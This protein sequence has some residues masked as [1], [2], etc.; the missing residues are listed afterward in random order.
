MSSVFI[1]PATLDDLTDLY[2]VAIK[3]GDSGSDATGMFRN[4]DMIGEVYVGP[5]VT[6]A[7]E[8]CFALVSKSRAVGYGLCVLD[9]LAFQSRAG[10]SWWPQLQEKY[11]SLAPYIES[12]WLIKE[13]FHPTPSPKEILDE[14]PSHGHIDLLPEFQGQGW[15]RKVMESMETALASLGSPGFHLRVSKHNIRGLKFYAALGYQEIMSRESEVIVGKRLHR[16]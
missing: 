7:T 2:R 10:E 9:T 16:E 11:H 15:G 3:T 12:E 8:T 5:Y 1:R 4:D 14:Y 13:I 6:L